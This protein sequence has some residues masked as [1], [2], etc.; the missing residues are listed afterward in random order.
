[1]PFFGSPVSACFWVWN[2]RNV[3]LYTWWR[4]APAPGDTPNHLPTCFP[5]ALRICTTEIPRT[6]SPFPHHWWELIWAVLS[7]PVTFNSCSDSCMRRKKKSLAWNQSR[8]LKI[9]IFF[10]HKVHGF[11]AVGSWGNQSKLMLL[12]YPSKVKNHLKHQRGADV[13][14]AVLA[15]HWL[16]AVSLQGK[17]FPS[18]ILQ[19]WVGNISTFFV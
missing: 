3:T 12:L 19:V 8:R 4:L 6:V 11:A 16:L 15:P 14:W 5:A 9:G 1:M 18:L 7:L 17:P 13:A 10:I 2:Q